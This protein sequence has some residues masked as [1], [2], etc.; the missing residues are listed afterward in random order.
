M[1]TSNWRH[2]FVAQNRAVS[3]GL[4]SNIR[5]LKTFFFK[6][7]FILFYFYKDINFNR[8][9]QG[10]TSFQNHFG[11]GEK[12][13]QKS[14]NPSLFARCFCV[15]ALSPQSPLS[16]GLSLT[17]RFTE[18][19][20][21]LA[22]HHFWHFLSWHTASPLTSKAVKPEFTVGFPSERKSSHDAGLEL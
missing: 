7:V 1:D 8:R 22:Q 10:L 9:L 17:L 12:Y 13:L 11:K 14:S 5:F 4:K 19:S 18:H 3:P 6:G 20:W 21:A 16:P 2:E 15:W